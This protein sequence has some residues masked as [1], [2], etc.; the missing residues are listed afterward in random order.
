MANVLYELARE[1][2][3]SGNINWN[4]DTIRVVLID[5]NDYT[6][7]FLTD[8]FF[9][10]IPAAAKVASGSL[11]SLTSTNGIADADNLTLSSV[12]GDQSEALVVMKQDTDDN[13]S[14]LI[15]FIDTATGLPVTPSGGD[16]VIT[17]DTALS[18]SQ[19]GIFKL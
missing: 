5:T 2:F 9:T 3:L 14:P 8:E 4:S 12:S 6:A 19:G 7:N 17:W 18:G 13:D 15:A 10:D 16:I 1:K 11:A